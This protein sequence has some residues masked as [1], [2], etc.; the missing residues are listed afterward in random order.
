MSSGLIGCVCYLPIKKS[1][2][3]MSL[4]TWCSVIATVMALPS[5]STSGRL[6]LLL[7]SMSEATETSSS[8]RAKKKSSYQVGSL[9]Q[10]EVDYFAFLLFLVVGLFGYIFD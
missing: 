7:K 2:C 3:N 10:A 1:V 9:V 8:K 6:L 5:P 4:F